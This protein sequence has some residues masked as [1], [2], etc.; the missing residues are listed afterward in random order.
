[1]K[2]PIR[3]TAVDP[4][5]AH[6]S[7]FERRSTLCLAC[8]AAAGGRGGT[9]GPLPLA[10]PVVLRVPHPI[11]AMAVDRS[12]RWLA[13]LD[14]EGVCLWDLHALPG[15]AERLDRPVEARAVGRSPRQSPMRA[16]WPFILMG[17]LVAVAIDRGV[18]VIDL[19]GKTLADIP[20]AHDS[21]VESDR[22]RRQGGKDGSLLASGDVSGLIRVWRVGPTGQLSFLT[23]LTG[24]TGAVYA[25][26]FSPDGRT[27]ASGG[28]DR[29]VLLWDP[30][31]GQERAVLTGHTDR[32]L[33]VQFLSD[34]SALLSVAR[35]GGVK[36]SRADRGV[37][38]VAPRP[39]PVGESRRDGPHGSTPCSRFSQCS[40]A[41]GLG[42]SAECSL[43]FHRS[44]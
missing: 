6:D 5:R 20:T 42:R 35:D 17:D 14:A 43:P 23:A 11:Y 40:S 27:L 13:T 15:P 41:S 29:T 32:I 10:R 4:G 24:H 38:T 33:R 36:R 34:S 31:S 19:K 30:V 2:G 18:R 26:A 22:V 1:M 16:N 21:K 3:A 37:Q 39:P 9:S 7:G 25:L 44:S 12:G 28:H 8:P